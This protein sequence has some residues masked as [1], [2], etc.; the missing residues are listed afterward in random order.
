MSYLRGL[1]GDAA[2]DVQQEVWLAVYLGMR[3]LSN[4]RA[5]RTWL[6]R[7]TRHRAIDY[8]RMQKRDALLVD[9]AD[10]ADVTL[11]VDDSDPR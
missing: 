5:F 9:V 11:P 8:L 3:H 10:V 2:D 1:V 6:F 7:T 4:P